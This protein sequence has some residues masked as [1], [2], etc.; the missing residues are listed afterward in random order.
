MLAYLSKIAVSSALLMGVTY[1]LNMV[2]GGYFGA[3]VYH[4]SL[5]TFFFAGAVLEPATIR[6][7]VVCVVLDLV[8]KV[9]NRVRK[10]F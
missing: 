6:I 1:S 9:I 4:L 2:L 3:V 10:V 7:M 5:G 8:M